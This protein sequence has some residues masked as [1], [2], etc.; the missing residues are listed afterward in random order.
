M[1]AILHALP[2]EF[3]I[4][5]GCA[6]CAFIIANPFDAVKLTGKYFKALGKP[7]AYKKEDYIELFSA[8]FIIKT[9]KTKG[10]LALE[11]HIEKPEES[12]LFGRF[13]DS[14]ITTMR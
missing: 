14:S 10:W 6:L 8:L 1:E 4:I 7:A 9:A 12:E 5:M 13:R 11:Q 2:G 3:V